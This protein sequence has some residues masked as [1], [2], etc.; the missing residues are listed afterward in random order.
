MVTQFKCSENIKNIMEGVALF[1]RDSK[2]GKSIYGFE[3]NSLMNLL[4][5]NVLDIPKRNYIL[6]PDPLL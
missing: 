2:G 1:F 5:M 6:F 4:K 3:V